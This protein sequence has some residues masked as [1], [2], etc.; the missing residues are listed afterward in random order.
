[1][2]AINE[3]IIH[4]TA[5]KAGR[6]L[7]IDELRAWHK[8]KGFKD[9]GYHYVV[10]P[11][12]E[13]KNCRPI[14]MCGAHCKGHNANSIGLAYV[15]GLDANGKPADTR[16]QQ[17]RDALKVAVQVLRDVFGDVPVRGH[18][19]YANKACPCFDVHKEFG[20]PPKS[21]QL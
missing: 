9:V 14:T 18:N 7:T 5:T 12:G 1:M 2:R 6:E 20:K 13:I 11:D 17:Q 21:N 8:Q 16:T 3:I 10:M 4:C 15:G 19:E